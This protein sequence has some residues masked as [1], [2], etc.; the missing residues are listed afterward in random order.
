M[1]QKPSLGNALAGLAKAGT[2]R[3]T[4]SMTIES[5]APKTF[6]DKNLDGRSIPGPKTGEQTIAPNA[7]PGAKITPLPNAP[8]QASRGAGSTKPNPLGLTRA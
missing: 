6:M 2:R 1:A 4:A 8:K 3:G 7:K 5:A